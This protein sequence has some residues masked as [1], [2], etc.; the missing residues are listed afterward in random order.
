MAQHP[1]PETHAQLLEKIPQ[2]TGKGLKHWFAC[3]ESGP[4]LLRFEERVGWLRDHCGLPHGFASA[5]V[6]EADLRRRA[7]R[8]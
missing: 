8:T 1:S 5:I 6:H 3:L 7:L 2:V 4:G